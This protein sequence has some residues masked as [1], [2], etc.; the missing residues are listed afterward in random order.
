MA[1]RPTMSPDWTKGPGRPSGGPGPTPSTTPSA[2]ASSRCT[3]P[4]RAG[5]TPPG[6]PRTGALAL[7]PVV[8]PVSAQSIRN[9]AHAFATDPLARSIAGR[10]R[11][12]KDRAAPAE[13]RCFFYMPFMHARTW[14]PGP[15]REPVRGVRRRDRRTDRL[16][17]ASSTGR[18]SAGSDGF[19]HSQPNV[20][21][22]HEREE[23][24][25][26]RWRGFPAKPCEDVCV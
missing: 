10:H 24:V 8:R 26:L 3:T 7:V 12:G 4:P 20:R 11:T 9:S 2:C 16:K 22:R 14:R 19:P 15:G 17:S 21:P 18:S 23:R 5:N 13:L 6:R 25:F 1:Q